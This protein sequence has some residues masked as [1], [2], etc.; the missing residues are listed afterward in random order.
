MLLERFGYDTPAAFAFASE[1][2]FDTDLGQMEEAVK[3]MYDRDQTWDSSRK[4]IVDDSL[5]VIGMFYNT[6]S[7]PP[8]HK[9]LLRAI[10][11]HFK[12]L[13]KK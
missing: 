11:E 13:N 7:I 10:R 8:G 6:F 3:K 2:Q 12:P 4:K 1:N 9:T 5:K